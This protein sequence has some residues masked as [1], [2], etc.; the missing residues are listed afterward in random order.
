M[1]NLCMPASRRRRGREPPGRERDPPRR[2][3]DREVVSGLLVPKLDLARKG[4]SRG[5]RRLQSAHQEPAKT[6]VAAV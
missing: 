1:C 3:D 2:A 6:K 4:G 5:G